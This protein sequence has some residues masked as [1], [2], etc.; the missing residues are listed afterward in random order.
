MGF[1]VSDVKLVPEAPC[2]QPAKNGFPLL[3]VNK[4]IHRESW[5]CPFLLGF[6]VAVARV[7]SAGTRDVPS[8]EVARSP[9]Q[10][11]IDLRAQGQPSGKSPPSWNW[12]G[13]GAVSEG[14]PQSFEAVA[15]AEI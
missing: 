1:P 11:V 4:I 5:P 13:D 6:S 3:I 2:L 10:K 7:V 14:S 9:N 8:L 12:G 15:D